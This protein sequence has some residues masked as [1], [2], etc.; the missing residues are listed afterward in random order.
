MPPNEKTPVL[1]GV[2]QFVSVFLFAFDSRCAFDQYRYHVMD[3]FHEPAL[4]R[5]EGKVIALVFEDFYL[6]CLQRAHQRG[7]A[8]QH[9]EQPIHTGQLHAIHFGAEQLLLGR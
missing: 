6:A 1:T 9:F 7:M 4:D 2:L 8:V 3:D 5:E